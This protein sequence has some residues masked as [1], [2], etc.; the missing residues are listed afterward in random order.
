MKRREFVVSTLGGVVGFSAMSRASGQGTTVAPNLATLANAKR[1][2]LINR[3]ASG[4]I[5]GARHGVRLDAGRGEG[6]ALLPGVEFRYGT[7]ACDIRGQDVAQQSF[8]G[9]AF[10]GDGAAAYDGVYFRPFNF[11]A[12][13]PAGRSHAVQYHSPPLY[14]WQKLRAERPGQ[15]EQAVTPAPD[16]N[17]WFHARIVVADPTVRVFVGD[18]KD[19]CLVVDLLNDRRRGSVGVWV[20]NNSGGEFAN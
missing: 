18:A 6:L 3:G 20:G 9:V 10:H 8:V 19:P 14:T 4:F 12:A 17:E 16:P 15:F 11:N 13:D 2:T 7:I 1:L 5:D